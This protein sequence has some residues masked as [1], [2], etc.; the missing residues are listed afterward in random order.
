VNRA[1]KLTAALLLCLSLGLH[2]VVL[3]SVAWTTMLIE[4]TQTTSFA[5]AL[6]TTFDGQH[7]CKICRAVREGHAAEKKPESQLKL[8]KLEIAA[9][10]EVAP[11]LTAADKPVLVIAAGVPW[12]PRAESPAPP[13]PRTA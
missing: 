6:K 7:P 1:L 4:R 2:W 3:Q 13:P 12:R 5:T 11:M 8:Q 9:P 10:R